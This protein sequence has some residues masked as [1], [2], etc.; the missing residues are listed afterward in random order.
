M[1]RFEVT[2]RSLPPHLCY[3]RRPVP[4]VTVVH[5]SQKVMSGTI[6]RMI[7]IPKNILSLNDLSRVVTLPANVNTFGVLKT[8]AFQSWQE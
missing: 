8:S 7:D 2:D 6:G 4:V 1:I 5:M 3:V